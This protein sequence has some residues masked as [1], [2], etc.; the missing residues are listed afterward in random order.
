METRPFGRLGRVSALTLGGGGIGNVWGDVDRAEAIATVR[1]ALDAGIT[2]LDLAPTYGPGEAELV[3][4]EALAGNVPEGVLITTKIE[5][6]DDEAGGRETLVERIGAG[7]RGSRERLRV[8]RIDLYLL[9]SQVKPRQGP[10]VS[11]LLGIDAFRDIVRPELE[12]LRE[13][14]AIGA[15]GLTAV[16]HPDALVELFE[17][18]PKPDA[19]QCVVNALD[20]SGDMWIWGSDTPPENPRVRAAAIAAGI[21]IVAIRAVAAGSLTDGLDRQVDHDHPAARDHR[22]AAG[23]RR[24]AAERGE[25][26]AVLAHRYALSVAG[27]ATVVLG[28]KNREE[29]AQ[30]LAAEAAGP[31]S[32][33]EMR[34]VEATATRVP[35]SPA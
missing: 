10:P 8:D 14:G 15:W 18:A 20:L 9:H 34:A 24:L 30:C 28:V 26:A 29:L 33:E 22:A 3:V 6:P 23:F 16:G 11:R 1:A 12:R 4:G 17:D 31:L 2:M 19:V 32:A 5:L 7:L 13:S 35:P 25:P 21:P 27:V